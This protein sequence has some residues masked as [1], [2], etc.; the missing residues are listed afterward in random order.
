MYTNKVKYVREQYTLQTIF[1]ALMFVCVF[2]VSIIYSVKYEIGINGFVRLYTSLNLTTIWAGVCLLLSI[3]YYVCYKYFI[4]KRKKF[5]S[6]GNVYTGEI[7]GTFAVTNW[8]G[9]G[10]A[11]YIKLVIRYDG[12]EFVTPAMYPDMAH[13]I[14]GNSCKVY[15]LNNECYA[16]DFVVECYDKNKSDYKKVYH[17]DANKYLFRN[18]NIENFDYKAFLKRRIAI[19]IEGSDKYILPAPYKVVLKDGVSKIIVIDIEVEQQDKTLTVFSTFEGELNEYIQ[20]NT[21]KINS[22]QL[23]QFSEQLRVKLHELLHTY[24]YFVKIKSVDIGIL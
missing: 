10:R 18:I 14:V 13:V 15:V 12:K 9:Q 24:Y 2:I 7:I 8:F 17:V 3:T 4:H 6:R 21:K 22:V 16:S 1:F 5:L 11:R 23:T 20:T 19:E